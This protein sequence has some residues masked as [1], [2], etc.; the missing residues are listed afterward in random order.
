MVPIIFF[1]VTDKREDYKWNILSNPEI[2]LHLTSDIYSIKETEDLIIRKCINIKKFKLNVRNQ[3]DKLLDEK[4][5]KDNNI[6]L[7]NIHFNF[8]IYYSFKDKYITNNFS[9]NYN[10]LMKW[11]NN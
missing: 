3:I 11:V 7:N 5:I 2:F 4:Y 1:T 6:D 8:L 10:K 9:I